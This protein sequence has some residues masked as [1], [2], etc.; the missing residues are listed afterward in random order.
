MTTPSPRSREIAEKIRQDCVKQVPDDPHF[1]VSF[2]LVDKIA[3]ALEAEYQEGFRAAQ[4]KAAEIADDHNGCT[5]KKCLSESNCGAT[6]A[7]QIPT[8]FLCDC[9]SGFVDPRYWQARL[10][11]AEAFIMELRCQ[12]GCTCDNECDKHL[13]L[14]IAW[15]KTL[16]PPPASRNTVDKS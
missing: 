8:E 12:N 1:F 7:T 4:E 11:A 2:K 5:D 10:N 3:A 15:K 14:E 6:I 13:P 9:G 16:G